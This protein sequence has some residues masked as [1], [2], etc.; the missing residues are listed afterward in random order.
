MNRML[1][2]LVCT[3]ALTLATGCASSLFAQ[4]E[5]MPGTITANE[6]L[7]STQGGM[8]PLIRPA[9][10]AGLVVG[11][12]VPFDL[13]YTPP[14]VTPDEEN[15]SPLLTL[16]SGANLS[17]FVALQQR[18]SQPKSLGD[19]HARLSTRASM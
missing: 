3:M 13:G 17:S 6:S 14:N 15:S 11:V 16:L 12:R 18:A 2:A 10:G 1:Q 19:L 7:A 5:R 8:V 9:R 4:G